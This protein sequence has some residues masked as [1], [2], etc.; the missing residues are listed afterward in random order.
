[1]DR[2]ASQKE[3]DKILDER[4]AIQ[5]ARYALCRKGDG[6]WRASTEI[7]RLGYVREYGRTCFTYEQKSGKPIVE[8]YVAS[9][10]ETSSELK[11]A[12]SSRWGVHTHKI[13]KDA[14]PLP[15]KLQQKLAASGKKDDDDEDEDEEEEDEDDRKARRK[16][17]R[18]SANGSAKKG[19]SSK[20]R[21]TDEDEDDEDEEESE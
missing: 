16:K 14:P 19:S 12:F 5:A 17:K 10:S 6:L 1:M 7:S 21:T 20:R 2:G 9:R 3:E 18:S 15:K 8:K 11:F 13:I 4:D